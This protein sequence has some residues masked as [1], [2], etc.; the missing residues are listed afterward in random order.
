[1]ADFCAKR[2]LEWEDGY[3]IKPYVPRVCENDLRRV[4][5]LVV[6]A[7]TDGIRDLGRSFFAYS[8]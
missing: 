5:S 8:R 3:A 2:A 4:A 1:M 7:D 6:I